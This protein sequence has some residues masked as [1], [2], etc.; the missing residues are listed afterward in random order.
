MENYQST[1]LGVGP[2]SENR[3]ILPSLTAAVTQRYL[4]L[5]LHLAEC[6]F[7]VEVDEVGFE[8]TPK[9]ILNDLVYV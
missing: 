4:N 5:F 6:P 7:I 8:S 2:A 9:N 3:R 1:R